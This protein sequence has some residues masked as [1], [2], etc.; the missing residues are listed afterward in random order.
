MAKTGER[1][2]EKLSCPK[3]ERIGAAAVAR[4]NVNLVVMLAQPTLVE[5]RMGSG[6]CVDV[7]GFVNTIYVS[8]TS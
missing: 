3:R 1:E 6:R 5:A 7:L 4:A 2:S 8:G